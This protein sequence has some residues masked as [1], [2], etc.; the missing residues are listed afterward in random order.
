VQVLVH[1]TSLGAKLGR[2][3]SSIPPDEHL[4]PFGVPHGGADVQLRHAGV[5]FNNQL[6]Q[7]IK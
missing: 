1:F 6:A 7:S 5:D 3:S 2:S 4:Q